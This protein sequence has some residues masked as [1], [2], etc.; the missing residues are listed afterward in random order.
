MLLCALVKRNGQ[1]GTWITSEMRSAYSKLHA[2][3]F[4]HS[5][6]AWRG[7]EL[8]GG[9]YGLLMD[10]VFFGESM[11]ALEPDASK[12]ALVALISELSRRGVRLVDCQQQTQHLA[13][14]GARP[15]ARRQFASELSLLIQLNDAPARWPVGEIEVEA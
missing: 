1:S 4:A 7:N 13:T 14:F 12:V 8:V 15:V 5:V 2:L 11:F 6:E 10:K 3:G 9:L